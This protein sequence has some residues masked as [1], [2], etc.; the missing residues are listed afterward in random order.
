MLVSI[1]SPCLYQFHLHETAPFREPSFTAHNPQGW[2][3]FSGTAGEISCFW[4]GLICWCLWGEVLFISELGRCVQC[5][6]SSTASAQNFRTFS[7]LPIP[8]Y[9]L[10]SKGKISLFLHLAALAI[11]I[12]SA[13]VT[14]S[15]VTEEVLTLWHDSLSVFYLALKIPV[16]NFPHSLLMD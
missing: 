10:C 16:T 1:P 12:M 14:H 8:S 13:L 15:H 6:V 2:F 11:R 4:P 7:F 9:C 5:L 3:A